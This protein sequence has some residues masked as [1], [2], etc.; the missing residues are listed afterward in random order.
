[1]VWVVVS[2]NVEN[3]LGP[4][5]DLVTA[6]PILLNVRV[7]LSAEFALPESVQMQH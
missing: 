6:P 4:K 2:I 3:V 5:P 7:A 1:M